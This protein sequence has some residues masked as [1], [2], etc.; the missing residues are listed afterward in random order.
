[1]IEKHERE[2]ISTGKQKDEEEFD[3]QN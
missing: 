1:L 3:W 2:A